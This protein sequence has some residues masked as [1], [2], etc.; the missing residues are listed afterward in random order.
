M[1]VRVVEPEQL[2]P[3]AVDRGLPPGVREVDPAV[4]AQLGDQVA[5]LAHLA[6]RGAFRWRRKYVK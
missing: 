1:D 3:P 4:G 5:G 6:R 2:H